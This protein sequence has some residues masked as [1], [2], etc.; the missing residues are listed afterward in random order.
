[1]HQRIIQIKDQ[2]LPPTSLLHQNRI[3]PAISPSLYKFPE[4]FFVCDFVALFFVLFLPATAAAEGP[5]EPS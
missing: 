5:E 3:N 1:M 4:A 2:R